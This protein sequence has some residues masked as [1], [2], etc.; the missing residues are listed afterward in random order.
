MLLN[1]QW[2]IENIKEEIFKNLEADEKNSLKSMEQSKSSSKR[3]IY[4]N[5]MIPWET[6]KISET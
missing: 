6:R 1:N 2:I 5:T 4:S 3:D